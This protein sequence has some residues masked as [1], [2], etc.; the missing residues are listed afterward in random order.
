MMDEINFLR[1]MVKDLQKHIQIIKK[2]IKE[3][4]EESKE[5]TD[6][7]TMNKIIEN[8]K[9]STFAEKFTIRLKEIGNGIIRY[10]K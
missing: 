9:N 8:E 4:D 6:G 7:E 3:L 2:R 1:E 10:Y 5:K